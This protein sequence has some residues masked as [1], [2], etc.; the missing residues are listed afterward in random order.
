MD[1][2][3]HIGLNKAASTYIQDTL[4]FN[5]K[6][7]FEKGISYPSNN[8]DI[9]KDI[10]SVQI[11]NAFKLNSSIKHNKWKN[12]RKILKITLEK[13]SNLKKIILSNE[14]LYK[15]LLIDE[16]A[17]KLSHIARSIGFNKIIL[18][19]VFRNIYSHAVSAYCHRS[20]NPDLPPFEEWIKPDSNNSR[21][22]ALEVYEFWNDF[23]LFNKKLVLNKNYDIKVISNEII[24]SFSNILNHKLIKI[25]KPKSNVSPNIYESEIL[26]IMSKNWPKGLIKNYRESAKNLEPI[27]K[28]NDLL[29]RSKYYDEID[30]YINFIDDDY[31]IFKKHFG[32]INIRERPLLN[33]KSHNNH[34]KSDF[35]LTENQISTLLE[36]IQRK[37]SPLENI[38]LK[39]KLIK[40]FFKKSI[41][42]L[43]VLFS[44][45]FLSD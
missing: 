6:K 22:H 19:V 35:V 31:K 41:S 45:W 23:N 14:S 20:G 9:S 39:F 33:I 1:L 8:E 34:N 29:I 4:L 30:K 36:S 44:S 42:Q 43:K 32:E 24:D 5:K 13:N 26:G 16:N 15:Y 7:L 2:I 3:L 28:V 10:G 37:N 40:N 27:F 21:Q 18:I 11:G 12:V 38:F 25:S 17:F